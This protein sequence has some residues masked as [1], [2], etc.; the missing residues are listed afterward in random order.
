MTILD[1]HVSMPASGRPHVS[2]RDVVGT[3]WAGFSACMNA[4]LDWQERAR[5]RRQL[6]GLSNRA[7][8]D[9]GASRADADHEGGKPAWCE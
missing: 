3:L 4:L 2:A 6:L 5:Q 9:F 7:L 8:R 1:T